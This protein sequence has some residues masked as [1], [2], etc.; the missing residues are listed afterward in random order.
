MGACC[1][2][3]GRRWRINQTNGEHFWTICAL[4]QSWYCAQLYSS[5]VRY[6]KREFER[7]VQNVSYI[8]TSA[9]QDNRNNVWKLLPPIPFW[10][11]TVF[12]YFCNC[13]KLIIQQA[14]SLQ[15][16]ISQ[17]WSEKRASLHS[18]LNFLCVQAS[19]TLS[20]VAKTVRGEYNVQ[21]VL[22]RLCYSVL[23]SNTCSKDFT[24][25][26]PLTAKPQSLFLNE[27]TL[28]W[29][30]HRVVPYS[31]M[32]QGGLSHCSCVR[33]GK[34]KNANAVTEGNNINA[35]YGLIMYDISVLSTGEIQRS[36]VNQNY[37]TRIYSG[38]P[39]AASKGQASQISFDMYHPWMFFICNAIWSS[40]YYSFSSGKK[41][42]KNKQIKCV[43]TKWWQTK[44][45]K[46][47][48]HGC[49]KEK[50]VFI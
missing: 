43:T 16:V 39:V 28:K 34:W 47:G 42:C 38:T 19:A 24:A 13:L 35:W 33:K 2:R 8:H 23:F 17:L 32:K 11:W 20:Q 40:Y 4:R 6:Y 9:H 27:T 26:F 50:S 12:K 48:S 18:I 3:E 46:K 14:Q 37:V 45:H 30:L 29:L 31:V 7:E 22:K 25:N 44:V 15:A 41:V 10:H 5:C 1:H 21:K 36:T 49:Y